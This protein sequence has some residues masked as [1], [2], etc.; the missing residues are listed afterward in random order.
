MHKLLSGSLLL[1]SVLLFS[2]CKNNNPGT[3]S[4]LSIIDT[5]GLA[6]GEPI[7][8][9]IDSSGEKIE[10]GKDQVIIQFNPPAGKVYNTS[11]QTITNITQTMF[12]Q[13]FSNLMD[14]STSNSIRVME[15]KPDSNIV[16]QSQVKSFKAHFKQDSLEASFQNGVSSDDP[17]IDM[18]RKIMDCYVDMPVKLTISRETDVVDIGGIEEIQSKINTQLGQ[19]ALM[20]SLQM[21]DMNQDIINSFVAFPHRPIAIGDTWKSTDSVDLGGVPAIVTNTFTLNSFDDKFALVSVQSEFKV[22]REMVRMMGGTGDEVQMSGYQ[23]GEITVAVASGWSIESKLEQNL[24]LSMEMQ[25]ESMKVSIKGNSTLK[26][27]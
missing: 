24:N 7:T 26:T 16:L 23:K 17:D 5:T 10:A 27:K 12:G 13:T 25:G 15:N 6:D 19:E 21:S 8:F 22:D 18:I 20:A 14:I 11:M 3:T 9:L 4:D 1:A 2:Q